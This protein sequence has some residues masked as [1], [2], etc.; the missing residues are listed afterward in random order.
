MDAWTYYRLCNEAARLGIPMSLDDPRSPRTV[1]GLAEAV[2][3]A[4][5]A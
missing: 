2:K 3:R 1:A 4:K 5:V